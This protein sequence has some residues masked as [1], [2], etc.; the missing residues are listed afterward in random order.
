MYIF[1]I[2]IIGMERQERK[3]VYPKLKFGVAVQA[4]RKFFKFSETLVSL[5]PQ[6][7]EN[8]P[9]ACRPIIRRIDSILQKNNIAPIS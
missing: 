3:T 9:C 6:D 2:K 8:V 7:T 4:K 5:L 1:K